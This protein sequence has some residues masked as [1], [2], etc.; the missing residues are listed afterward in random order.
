[1]SNLKNSAKVHFEKYGFYIFKNL[2]TTQEIDN[3]RQN[4]YL[5]FEADSKIGLNYFINGTKAKSAKGDLLSKKHLNKIILNEKVINAAKS[6][7]GDDIVYFGDSNY[8]IGSG[9]RGYHR[10]NVDREYQK[11]QDWEGSYHLLRCGLYMQDHHKFSGG[12]KVKSGSHNNSSGKSIILNTQVG[13]LV[14]WSLRTL[15]SG[16]AVRLKVWPT[17]PIDYFERY[18]P[19][20]LK[21]EEA[22]ERIA[23]FFSFGIKNKNLD[24]Y[25]TEYL[26]KN[27]FATENLM[28]SPI[29]EEIKHELNSKGV[30][31]IT[32]ITEYGV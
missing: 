16:N 27:K 26:Q 1:M 2:F 15:H 12:L 9:L 7:L 21:I 3:L 22:K 14:V 32:P 4:C 10:D 19:D 11:G 29:S 13:D 28:N 6:I 8:Q 25:I 18:I 31:L 23:C 20:T 24:R 30:K 17:L 5:Q